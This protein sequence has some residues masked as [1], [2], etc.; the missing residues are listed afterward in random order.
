M[1][2]TLRSALFCI[3]TAFFPTLLAQGQTPDAEKA[4]II[5]SHLLKDDAKAV[6]HIE[7]ITA[8]IKSTPFSLE[9]ALDASRELIDA[10][11]SPSEIESYITPCADAVAAVET[12]EYALD[13]SFT[14]AVVGIGKIRA[15]KDGAEMFA[16]ATRLNYLKLPVMET[17]ADAIGYTVENTKPLI[18]KGGFDP[19]ESTEMI[20]KEFKRRY[21]GLA[22]KLAKK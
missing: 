13:S 18:L 7:T 2:H 4:K 8:L 1:K 19:R 20:L 14:R 22:A 9:A 11:L 15:S 16:A 6:K 10:G 3:L 17:F 12:K 5:F 21:G